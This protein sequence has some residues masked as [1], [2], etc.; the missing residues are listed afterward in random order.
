MTHDCER[1]LSRLAEVLSDPDADPQ[2]RLHGVLTSGHR[3]YGDPE[4]LESAV[5]TS[6]SLVEG[7]FGLLPRRGVLLAGDDPARFRRVEVLDPT[8]T[9]P[10]VAA[11]YQIIDVPGGG[12]EDFF[13]APSAL[14]R[15]D[16]TAAVT[17]LAHLV[18]DPEVP[19]R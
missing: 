5:A 3:L 18:L 6:L 2:F 16:P 8:V 19:A 4:D 13:L 17:D 12:S 10:F 11:A 7:G 1:A 15:L 9:R 14:A